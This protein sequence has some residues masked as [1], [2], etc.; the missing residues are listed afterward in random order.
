M[1]CNWIPIHLFQGSTDQNDSWQLPLALGMQW[2]G[3]P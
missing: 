2:P 3:G 1:Q